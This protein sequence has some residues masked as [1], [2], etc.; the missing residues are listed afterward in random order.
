MSYKKKDRPPLLWGMP[1]TKMMESPRK[2]GNFSSLFSKPDP[3]EEND[4][5]GKKAY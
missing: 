2:L 3:E 1:F 5:W 4:C